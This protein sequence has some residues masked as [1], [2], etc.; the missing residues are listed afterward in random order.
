MRTIS[1]IISRYV[2]E[3][4]AKAA[5]EATSTVRDQQQPAQR[6]D[7]AQSR[8]VAQAPAAQSNQM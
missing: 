7:P 6:N 1:F 5:Y 3:A 4:L 2:G 8:A